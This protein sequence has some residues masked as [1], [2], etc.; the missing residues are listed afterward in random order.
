MIQKMSKATHNLALNCGPIVND[1]VDTV[2][3]FR[4]YTDKAHC[5]AEE[6]LVQD[7]VVLF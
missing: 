1:L 3:H 6:D 7:L 5:A 4:L 2:F